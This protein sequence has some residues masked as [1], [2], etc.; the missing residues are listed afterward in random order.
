MF[1]LFSNSDQDEPSH[2]SPVL[3]DAG[4]QTDQLQRS[5]LKDVGCQDDQLQC[6]H[7]SLD[8]QFQCGHHSVGPAGHA[9]PVLI[10][11]STLATASHLPPAHFDTGTRTD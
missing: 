4:I 5:H 7:L 2:A 3:I 10:D 9:S 1:D 6:G 11:A 8:D